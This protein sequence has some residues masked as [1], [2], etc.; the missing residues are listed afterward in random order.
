MT[1]WLCLLIRLKKCPLWCAKSWMM[2]TKGCS[3]EGRL[4]KGEMCSFFG[5]TSF[6][7]EMKESKNGKLVKELEGINTAHN[8]PTGIRNLLNIPNFSCSLFIISSHFLPF[9]DL[10]LVSILQTLRIMNVMY[11]Y[12]QKLYCWIFPGC[13]N[14]NN[15]WKRGYCVWLIYLHRDSWQWEMFHSNLALKSL[16]LLSFF[17]FCAADTKTLAQFHLF[18]W[19]Q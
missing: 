14:N 2:R 17:L 1:E 16:N 12:L 4:S 15:N 5:V 10:Q 13:I 11:M 8:S 7:S 9:L 3:M 6:C 19:L 18:L